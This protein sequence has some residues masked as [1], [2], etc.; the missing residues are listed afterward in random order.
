MTEHLS[1]LNVLMEAWQTPGESLVFGLPKGPRI[2]SWMLARVDGSHRQWTDT[3][4][5]R[6]WRQETALLFLSTSLYLCCLLE[7]AAYLGRG[8][9][10]QCT[11]SGNAYKTYPAVCLLVDSRP[12]NLSGSQDEPSYR[13]TP[14]PLPPLWISCHHDAICHVGMGFP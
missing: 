3:F 8:T 2:W 10:P 6:K 4:S 13:A 7:G 11:L 14:S 9:F 1:S 12:I 5:S